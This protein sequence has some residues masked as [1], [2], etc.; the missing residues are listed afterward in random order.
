MPQRK[1]PQSLYKLCETRFVECITSRWLDDLSFLEN[2][3]PDVNRLLAGIPYA[4][5]DS[6]VARVLDSFVHLQQIDSVLSTNLLFLLQA[7]AVP[8]LRAVDFGPL[9]RIGCVD[10]EDLRLFEAHFVTLL[11]TLANITELSFATHKNEY[12]LPICSDRV[13]VEIGRNCVNLRVLNL[14]CC[15][16]VT[17]DGLTC[18]IPEFSSGRGCPHLEQLFI[19]ECSVTAS[20]VSFILTHLKE[21]RIID[22][23]DLCIPIMMLYKHESKVRRDGLKLT[24][25]NNVGFL[26]TALYKLQFHKKVAYAVNL[27]CPNLRNLCV[28]VTDFDVARF[29]HFP[30]LLSLELIYNIGT[31]TSPGDGT[32]NFLVQSGRQLHSLAL[33]CNVFHAD[34]YVLIGENCTSLRQLWIKCN[35]MV[36]DPEWTAPVTGNSIFSHLD[37]FYTKIGETERT[38][39]FLPDHLLTYILQNAK[40]LANLQLIFRSSSVSDT[41]FDRVL[42]S[43]YTDEMT[44]ILVAVPRHNNTVGTLRLSMPSVRLVLRL[45]P[46]LKTLGNLLVW[47]INRRQYTEIKTDIESGNYDL[48]IIYRQMRIT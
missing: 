17:N 20:G 23:R 13:L 12:T 9:V 14:S 48:N 6:I 33:I 29:C 25:I 22:F 43:I 46:R 18:L 38:E 7:I 1:S 41:W 40:K 2:C 21:L 42:T 16:H 3:A 31:P 44:K 19:F 32:R 11:P 10:D 5:A 8:H 45:C 28:R 27:L 37:S 39:G 36:C 26:N 24:H 35:D 30:S 47:N 34:Q 15:N 4:F